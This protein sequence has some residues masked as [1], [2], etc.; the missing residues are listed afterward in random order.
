VFRSFFL[1]CALFTSSIRPCLVFSLRLP[2][3]AEGP[4]G[5]PSLNLAPF[6]AFRRPLCWDRFSGNEPHIFLFS[7]ISPRRKQPTIGPRRFLGKVGGNAARD[8][9]CPPLFPWLHPLSDPKRAQM[10]RAV[11]FFFPLHACRDGSAIRRKAGL[12][13]PPQ[14]SPFSSADRMMNKLVATYDRAVWLDAV[15]DTR[16][17]EPFRFLFRFPW[18]VSPHMPI[19]ASE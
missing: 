9:P 17:I 6:W 16:E 3:K 7:K 10:R 12:P 19:H 15:A 11:V 8:R 2:I 18:S 4:V 5:D 1:F 13:F 14:A